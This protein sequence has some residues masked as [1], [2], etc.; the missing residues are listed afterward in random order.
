MAPPPLLP[1]LHLAANP[2][3]L[4]HRAHNPHHLLHLH[5]RFSLR[6]IHPSRHATAAAAAKDPSLSPPLADVEM[7]RG[8]DGVWT[9]RPPTVVV[10][11]DLDNKPPRGP[12]FPAAAAL[13]DAASLLGRVVS[14][15]AFA[16]R[17]AFSHVPSWV[18][19]ERRER[20]AMDRAE[21]A[22]TAAAP[23]VPYSCAVCGRR[24]PTR[25]DLARHFRNLHQRERNKKLNR[26]RSLKGKKRQKFRKRF[27]SGNTKYDDAA[28]ELITP[29]VGYG[30][31][32]EL[33][34]AGVNVRT[35]SDKPQAADHALKR[36]VKHSVACGV[37]WLVLVSDDS[38]FTDTVRKARA[39]DLRTVVVGDG[40]RALGSVADIWLPWNRVE[41][42]E[43]DEEMLRSGRHMGFRDEDMG[44][45]DEDE[46]DDEFV[47]DWDTSDLDGVVDDIVATRTKLFSATT[48]S[49][50]ADEEI[51]D[52]LLGVGINGG[53]MLW[54]SD[55]D[56]DGLAVQCHS[57]NQKT[58]WH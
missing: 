13:R 55:E 49:A 57:V 4:H 44:F 34:R 12:P 20:R 35:V 31:A 37:D 46:Q 5:R 26:L 48:M 53:D 16:N 11:W 42:G 30:L 27:I 56:E 19:D 7:V 51:M 47:V 32:S 3:P 9:A 28:R 8:K 21:R 58:A 40:C 52:D 41:N 38:D 50:F 22:G 17:H 43:V 33:R 45:R 36:Q 10:L 2:N 6:T 15:S 23:P 24:F 14:V 39:A 29:K 18:A 1:F 25:P 54:S